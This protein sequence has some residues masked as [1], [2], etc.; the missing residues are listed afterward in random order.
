MKKHTHRRIVEYNHIEG[1][2]DR[3]KV[4]LECGHKF[5]VNTDVEPYYKDLKIP[6][7]YNC[8]QCN[9]LTEK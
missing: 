9:E 3:M 1:F 8:T 5:I 4:Q 6:N 2:S 7:Y